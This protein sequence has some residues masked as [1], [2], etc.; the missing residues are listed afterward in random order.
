MGRWMDGD[1]NQCSVL[2]HRLIHTKPSFAKKSDANF[3]FIISA[4]LVWVE[5]RKKE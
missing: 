1:L 4:E 3:F 5:S 2:V